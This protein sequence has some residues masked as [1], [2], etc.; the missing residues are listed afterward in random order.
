MSR[1]RRIAYELTVAVASVG[2]ALLLRL[3]LHPLMG[4]QSPYLTLYP[5]VALA[6]LFG[7]WRAGVVATVISA[8]AAGW[9]FIPPYGRWAVYSNYDLLA[10]AFFAAATLLISL[11]GGLLSRSQKA[12]SSARLERI[13]ELR[14]SE[15]A[16]LITEERLRL[17]QQAARFGTFEWDIQNDN[18]WAPDLEP[19]YGMHPGEFKG[20][21]EDWITRLHPDDVPEVIRSIE[22][23]PVSG[24]VAFE[25]RAIWPDGTI[26][27][28]STRG[29]LYKDEQGNSVRMVGA[30]MDVTKLKQA[31]IDKRQAV[32]N[33]QT[34]LDAAPVGIIFS[35]AEGNIS[36]ASP[37]AN[38]VLGGLV[39]G[40]ASGPEPGTYR[41]C[42]VDG[43]PFPQDQMPL[44]RAVTQ[45]AR[46]ENVEMRVCRGSG[47]TAYVLVSAEPTHGAG[48][49]VTGA[50]ATLQDI[51]QLKL[52]QSDLEAQRALLQ[53]VLDSLPVAVW[54]ADEK[55][56]ITQLN[57]AVDQV[58]GKRPGKRPPDEYIDYKGWWTDS[59]EPV[60]PEDWALNRA[61]KKGEVST[62]EV[63]NIQ[64]FDGSRGTILNNASPIVD[65]QGRVLGGVAVAQDITRL[66]AAEEAL[67]S[68]QE[69]LKRL[70]DNL[71]RSNRDLQQFAYVASHDLQEPLRQVR[72]F[73]QLLEKRYAGEL[74]KTAQEYME[75]V[76]EGAKRMHSL[77]QDLL[78]FSRVDSAGQELHPVPAQSALDRALHSLAFAMK[79]NKATLTHDALPTVLADESQLAQVFQNLL[80]NAIKFRGEQNPVIHVGAER[81]GPEWMFSIRDNGIGFEQ[82]Y[83]DKMFQLFQRLHSRHA[84]GGT[85]IGLT[86]CKRVIERHGGRIWAESEPCKGSTFYFTLPAAPAP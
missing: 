3:A 18:I 35:D 19:L 56:T 41:L 42:T 48:G 64:R 49:E 7:G 45:N 58:W 55:G 6:A 17:A 4:D 83:A 27:W 63:I 14:N 2:A 50:V 86:I 32:E 30:N 68:S 82:Q 31:E 60:K 20:T 21:Y 73:V 66:R 61:T 37:E 16:L 80:G 74:D 24:E 12:L 33:L 9:L 15:E 77:V 40:K 22:E 8:V 54:I 70:V 85:G 65:S 59:G 67:R 1:T 36:Y 47:A 69:D 53:A 81:R 34:V 72:S 26:R 79:E 52:T 38:R 29:K 84:Y 43:A 51:T 10:L 23:A 25:F 11:F 28:L 57:K 44:V 62:G 71:A 13:R 78:A 75:F 39:K 76:A 5:A 46:V